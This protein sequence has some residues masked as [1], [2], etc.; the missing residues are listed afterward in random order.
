MGVTDIDTFM[1]QNWARAQMKDLNTRVLRAAFQEGVLEELPQSVQ[2][3]VLQ[4][5]AT[6]RPWTEGL[7]DASVMGMLAGMLTG[8]TVQGYM[9]LVQKGADAETIKGYVE[10]MQRN[11]GNQNFQREYV[12][13][14]GIVGGNK[15]VKLTREDLVEAA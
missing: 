10:Q 9:Q 12:R 1:T 15:Q 8:G 11:A 14:A 7:D 5:F 2:E 4:N 3:Q 13:L 6:G